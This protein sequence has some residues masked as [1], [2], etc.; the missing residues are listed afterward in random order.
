MLT[1]HGQGSEW[2]LLFDKVRR[3]NQKHKNNKHKSNRGK[4]W[5]WC[6]AA[7]L[8]CT[9]PR[10]TLSSICVLLFTDIFWLVRRTSPKSGDCLQ[11]VHKL[12]YKK[13]DKK[14]RKKYETSC[15]GHPWVCSIMVWAFRLVPIASITFLEESI[16]SNALFADRITPQPF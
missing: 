5:Y 1:L 12:R 9:S 14:K 2:S 15:Y 13:Q 10:A 6:A 8:I 3:T 7:C 4:N 11:S 16:T